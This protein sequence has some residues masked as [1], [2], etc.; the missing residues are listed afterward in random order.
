M[1]STS[2]TIKVFLTDEEKEKINKILEHLNS[3]DDVLSGEIE[4]WTKKNVYELL[5]GRAIEGYK[6]E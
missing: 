5:L 6:F 2:I 4:K 1:K 3:K